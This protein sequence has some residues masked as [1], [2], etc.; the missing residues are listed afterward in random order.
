MKNQKFLDITNSSLINGTKV[1]QNDETDQPSQ[2]WVFQLV[3]DTTSAYKIYNRNS[4][5]VLTFGATWTSQGNLFQANSDC[6]SNSSSQ[7]FQLVQNAK[8]S[9]NITAKWQP[10]W[11]VTPADDCR[12]VWNQ[13]SVMW[14][15]C[16]GY[17]YAYMDCQNLVL[18]ET[19]L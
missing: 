7:L 1:Q 6:N 14:S 18:Q 8:G 11:V 3:N 12:I 13:H 5:M 2:E 4:R 10:D 19:G 16:T 9:C 15:H 17:Y